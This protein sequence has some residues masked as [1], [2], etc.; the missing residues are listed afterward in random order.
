MKESKWRKKPS[1][2]IIIDF[3]LIDSDNPTIGYAFCRTR[4]RGRGRNGEIIA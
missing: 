1:R 2:K 4:S 3:I